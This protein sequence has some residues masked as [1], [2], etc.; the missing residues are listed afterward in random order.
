MIR[1]PP[2]STRV[3]SSAASDVYK[4][5]EYHSGNTYLPEVEFANVKYAF[6]TDAYIRVGRIT[7]P[8]FLE[9]ENR[10]IGYTYAW[11]HPPIELYRQEPTNHL[12]GV[13]VSY[14]LQMGE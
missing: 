3:R 6:T 4:R 7:L 9:S 11:I 13:D 1:R 8:T 2:R 5:Q 14:R 10:D 12:D